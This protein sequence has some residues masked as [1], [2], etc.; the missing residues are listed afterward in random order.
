[1]PL[2]KK[3]ACTELR[4]VATQHPQG[5]PP[6]PTEGLGICLLGSL[7]LHNKDEHLQWSIPAGGSW[8]PGWLA[9]VVLL[10]WPCSSWQPAATVLFHLLCLLNSG[11]QGS[12]VVGCLLPPSKVIFFSLSLSL[13]Q[14]LIQSLRGGGGERCSQWQDVRPSPPPH[15]RQGDFSWH[16]LNGN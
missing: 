10:P 8:Q 15:P 4:C 7:A 14:S 2:V 16:L 9:G 6:L 1:M 13:I 12:A 11:C 3:D 5:T